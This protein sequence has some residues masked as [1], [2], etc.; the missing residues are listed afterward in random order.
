MKRSG[1]L[2]AFVLSAGLCTAAF[3]AD[4]ITGTVKLDGKA[5]ER[6]PVAGLDANPQCKA[7]HKDPV[8]DETIVADDS[9]NLANVVVFLKGDNVKGAAPAEPAELDQ[10]GC[11][12]VPHVLSMTVGQQLIAKNTDPFLHNVHTLPENSEPSNTAQPTKDEVG[13]KLKPVKA[14]E[15]FKTKCDVHPWMSAWIAAFDHPFHAVTGEDGTYEINTKG[16][17][18]GTYTIIAWQEKFKESEP[19]KVT[20][21]AGKA[22]KPVN[23][24]FK[25]KAADAGKAAG[26]REVKLVSTTAAGEK[27]CCEEGCEAAAKT[28]VAVK[29]AK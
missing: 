25:M 16:L 10:V 15:I 2:S 28:T 1:W 13:I 27:P 18:D 19:Q 17:A 9:G 5:P 6:K 14:A 26:E 22:D 3:G 21:K 29:A 7:L 20:V 8:L 12:Y 11:Q 24:T 4:G 23:F